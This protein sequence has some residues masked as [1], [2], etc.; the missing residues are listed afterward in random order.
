[1]YTNQLEDFLYYLLMSVKNTSIISANVS[2]KLFSVQS[3]IELGYLIIFEN[4]PTKILFLIY[5]FSV[6]RMLKFG[7]SIKE[8][9]Y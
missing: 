4:F 1:M 9:Y 5:F 3:K 8:K 2:C 6:Y 7:K